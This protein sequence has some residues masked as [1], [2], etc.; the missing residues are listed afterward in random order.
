MPRQKKP[1]KEASQIEK[2]ASDRVSQK[3]GRGRPS[4]VRP[5]EIVGRAD[6]NRWILGQVW[7]RLWP[8]LSKAASEEEVTR[9]FQEGAGPYVTQ[10]VPAFSSLISEVLREKTFPQRRKPQINFL[11]DSV[12]GLGIVTARRSRDVCAAER[13][14]AKR[15]HHILRYE[16]YVECSCGYKGPSKDH[17]CRT[18]GAK[19]NQSFLQLNGRM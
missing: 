11:A 17:A 4:T 7:E 2:K 19:I 3:R 13:A 18:C 1:S 8:L 14:R 10:F 12:A 9:A 15:E 5:T 6:N 16:Y